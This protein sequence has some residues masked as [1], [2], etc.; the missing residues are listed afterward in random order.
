M[1]LSILSTLIQGIKL[2]CQLK[3]G[4]SIGEV[5]M[6]NA[7]N[8]TVRSKMML[9]KAATQHIPKNLNIFQRR[10]YLKGISNSIRETC[11]E[12]D[13]AEIETLVNS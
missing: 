1:I 12:S 9:K 4:Q 3:K 7:Q 2:Y 10:K 6:T 11:L 5:I 8:N 13:Q